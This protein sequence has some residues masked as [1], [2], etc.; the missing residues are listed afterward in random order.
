[1]R[2][3]NDMNSEILT[4]M[5]EAR[6]RIAQRNNCTQNSDRKSNVISG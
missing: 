5:E 4:R 1:M 2:D 6:G 3:F